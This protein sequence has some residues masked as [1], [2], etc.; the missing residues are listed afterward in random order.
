MSPAK[1]GACQIL[2]EGFGRVL[3]GTVHQIV[4]YSEVDWAQSWIPSDDN[5]FYC[6]LV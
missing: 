3:P 6:F 2:T 4:R 5:Y 1:G